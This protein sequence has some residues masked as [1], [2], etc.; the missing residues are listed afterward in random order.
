[1]QR[2]VGIG[3]FGINFLI[4]KKGGGIS[5]SY[6]VSSFTW[7]GV[8]RRPLKASWLKPI[9]ENPPVDEFGMIPFLDEII[10]VDWIMDFNKFPYSEDEAGKVS[11]NLAP[12][13]KAGK[14]LDPREPRSTK[15]S[16]EEFR[17]TA[18]SILTKFLEGY[19][20]GI[21]SKWSE[22]QAELYIDSMILEAKIMAV[23][24]P[25]GYINAPY[26]YFPEELDELFEAGKL[27]RKLDLTIPAYKRVGF[28]Q[29]LVKK[30]E[31]FKE[32]K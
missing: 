10:G 13:L 5:E 12:L 27:D 1:M 15:E 31:E 30:I 26:Y 22:E 18:Y 16:R 19:N 6:I 20:L 9:E 14:L 4:K 7:G 29:D 32:R 25:Q 23:T 3:Y 24:P 21:P 28:P 2:A 17:L 11:R 8:G